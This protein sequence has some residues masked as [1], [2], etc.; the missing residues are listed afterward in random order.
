MRKVIQRQRTGCPYSPA[1]DELDTLLIRAERICAQQPKDKN[2][3]YALHAP[4]VECIGK[5]KARRPSEFGVKTGLAITHEHGLIVGARTFP[6][7]PQ[8]GHTLNE[9]LEQSTILLEG[10][11]PPPK[12]AY[13]DF[14]YRGVDR[15]N[16]SLDL[17]NNTA[18][19]ALR[20]YVIWRKTSFFSQLERGDLFRARVMT[21]TESCRRLNLCA[22][23]LLRQVCEQGIRREPISIRL[24]IDHLYTPAPQNQIEM[25]RA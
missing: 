24:P 22:Y 19:R 9:Q 3:L 10:I 17:T 4:E 5:G 13:V 18:E 15:D 25:M 23:T 6:G 1:L 7:N 11:A 14:G 12:T 20:P 8:D 16:P 21:V 2:K